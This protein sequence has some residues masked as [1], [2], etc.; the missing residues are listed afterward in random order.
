MTFLYSMLMI[1]WVVL[2][3]HVPFA[4]WRCVFAGVVLISV[5]AGMAEED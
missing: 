4:W 1:I 2:L 3:F 5:I